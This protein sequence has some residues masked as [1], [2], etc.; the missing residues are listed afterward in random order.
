MVDLTTNTVIDTVAVGG[1]P[2]NLTLHV[3][4]GFVYTTNAASGD[5]SVIDT[6]SDMVVAT[7]PVGRTPYGIVVVGVPQPRTVTSV[8]P[9]SGPAAGGTPVTVTGTHFTGS[10]AVAFGPTPAASFTVVN[11]TTIVATAP[12]GAPGTVDVTVTGP[13]G[14]SPTSA[15]DRYI[16]AAAPTV[17]SIGP[18]SGPEAGG[19]V[20]TI[21]G[22]NLAGTTGVTFGPGRPATSLSCT[23][24][25]CTVTA[26]AGPGAGQ[27]D[28]R[29]STA[30]GTSASNPADRYTYIASAPM[31]RSRSRPPACRRCS[32]RTSTTRSPSPTAVR[33][34]SARRPSRRR[35][36]CR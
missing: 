5:V 6:A 1:Y 7:I 27:V 30:G 9:N 36:R 34:R 23:A 29:V 26:P 4:G 16:Y 24:T 35:C 20:V 33:T 31:W 12:P 17:T 19:T 3:A 10:T 21:T 15:A 28:V 32:T 11:D 18:N 14:T 8:T 22:T 2:A 25:S 13:N